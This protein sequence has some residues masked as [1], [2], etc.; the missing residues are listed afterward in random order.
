M[1]LMFGQSSGV[2]ESI[3]SGIAGEMPQTLG[4]ALA[5][6]HSSSCWLCWTPPCAKAAAMP[7]ALA[8]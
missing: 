8:A 7:R 4:L 5:A 6:V 2:A 3:Q 1:F